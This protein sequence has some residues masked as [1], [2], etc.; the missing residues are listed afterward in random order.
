MKVKILSSYPKQ[1]FE[2]GN[3]YFS[4]D[5][6]LNHEAII[7]F[8]RKFDNVKQMNN[9]IITEINSKVGKDDM[10]ILMGDTMMVN[11]DYAWFLDS[12]ICENVIMLFGNHCGLGRLTEVKNSCQ[13]DKLKYIGHYLEL[14]IDKQIICCS[15]YPMFNWNYQDDG[16][17]HLSGHLHGDEN[18]IIKQ[19]REYKCMDVGIDSYYNMFGEYSLFSF[20]KICDILKDKKVIGRHKNK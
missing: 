12:I 14:I 7:K 18:Y 20:A 11:K 16:S 1:T 10:L 8:G 15:H 2:I 19:M 4:S 6:H 5:L 17:F 3:I 13:F 9:H